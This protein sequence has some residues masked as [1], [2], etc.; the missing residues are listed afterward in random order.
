MNFTTDKNILRWILI[1]FAVWITSL[2]LWNTYL[3]F[4]KLKESERKNMQEYAIAL[5]DLG[6]QSLEAELGDLGLTVAGNTTELPII[7]E[8]NKGEL[9]ARNLPDEIVGDEVKLRALIE[10][11]KSQNQPIITK[12][13][14]E[15]FQTTYY[16]DSEIIQ[17]LKYYP[18]VVVL[19]LHFL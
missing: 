9:D 1:V 18:L 5:K 2:I 15:V 6:N 7:V 12:F 4:Q 16:G 11:Y 3:F 8:N 14:G 13:Q 10:E 19:Q 17:K